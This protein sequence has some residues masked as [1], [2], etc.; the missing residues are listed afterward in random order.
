MRRTTFLAFAL[1]TL[2]IPALEAQVPTPRNPGP[3]LLGVWEGPYQSEAVPPGNLKLTVGRNANREWQ[4]TLEIYADQPPEAGAVREFKVEEGR[5]SWAQDVAG[6]NCVST[7]TMVAGV[8]KGTA[9]CWQNG[10]VVV[11]A[12]F[13]LERKKS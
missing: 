10:T 9:E 5:I 2:S 3:D 1:A 13:L 7:A 12:T 8:M 6:M 4:V 11:T